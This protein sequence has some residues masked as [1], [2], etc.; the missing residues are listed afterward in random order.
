MAGRSLEKVESALSEIKAAGVKGE[1]S[2]VQLDVTDDDSI[3]KAAAHV[4]SKF[5]RLDVLVNNAGTASRNENT[6][7]RL[8]ETFETNVFGPVVV[9]ATFRP[10]LLESKN[11]YSVYVS[12]VTGSVT[13]AS[14]PSSGLYKMNIANAEGY[15]SSKS[16]LNMIAMHESAEFDETKIKIF[17]ACPGFVRSNLRGTSEEARSGWGKAGDPTDSGNMILDIIQ[18]RRDGDAK[19][20]VH[21]DGTYP[22]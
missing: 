8:R 14:D 20:F 16:A 13:L 5:G 4:K 11:P 10:L 12:S 6:R 22:W 9:S 2:A 17:T 15:R 1:L 19:K 3:E 7:I 21:K 18:G